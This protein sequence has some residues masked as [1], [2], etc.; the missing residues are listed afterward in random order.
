MANLD[1][2]SLI[3]G[4]LRSDV[5]H[6]RVWT[7]EHE[8]RDEARFKILADK[9]TQINGHGTRLAVVEDKIVVF[10]PAIESFKKLKWIAAGFAAAISL[11]GGAAAGVAAQALKWFT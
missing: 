8:E 6:I 5:K 4:E 7:R 9:I 1:E 2:I 3:L 10:E 11:V